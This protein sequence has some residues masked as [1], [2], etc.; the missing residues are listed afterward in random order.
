MKKADYPLTV[1]IVMLC[2]LLTTPVFSYNLLH[3]DTPS[4]QEYAASQFIYTRP[5]VRIGYVIPSDRSPQ[6]LGPETLQRVIR[7]AQVWYQEQMAL[8]GFA[9]K[10]FEF[11]KG[12]A[13]NPAVNIIHVDKTAAY[14]R[15]DPWTRTIA[16]ARAAG[17]NVATE[18]QVWLLVPEIHVQNPDGTV[19]DSFAFGSGGLSGRDAGIA[20]IGSDALAVLGMNGFNNDSNINGKI[21]PGLGP[22]PAN[23]PVH[24]GSTVSKVTSLNMGAILH[25]LGH[26]F[27]LPHDDRIDLYAF[28]HLMSSAYRSARSAFYPDLYPNEATLLSWGAALRLDVSHYFN[29]SLE[30]NEGPLVIGKIRSTSP[31]NGKLVFEY[32]ANDPDGLSCMFIYNNFFRKGEKELKGTTDKGILEIYDYTPGVETTFEMWVY[33]DEGNLTVE[34][35]TFTPT[36]NENRAPY[37]SFLWTPFRPTLENGNRVEFYANLSSD[38]DHNNSSLLFQWDFDSD[39]IF[40]TELSED[41]SHNHQFTN[42]GPH[43]IRLKVLDP[44]GAFSISPPLPIYIRETVPVELASFEVSVM[45]SVV[46]L[47]WTTASESKNYGFAVQ[48]ARKAAEPEWMTLDIVRGNGT[49]NKT[50]QYSYTDENPGS[51]TF[52]YRL[53]QMDTDGAFTLTGIREVEVQGL[54]AFNLMQ[55]HPNP[56]NSATMIRFRIDREQDVKFALI[57]L[58]GQIVRSRELGRLEAGTHSIQL[59]ADDLPSGVYFYQIQGSRHSAVKK[60]TI[61]R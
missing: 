32:Y 22:Y 3:D 58:Q 47:D 1:Y 24:W 19:D 27:G 49:T 7:Q 38:P 26:A 11:E 37:P 52:L 53:K 12:S 5:I 57:N 42:A 50:H 17:F 31:I 56:F 39:L 28:G 61:L 14:L 21:I 18:R 25:V 8:Y 60:L 23:F 6:T 48:R 9:S 35:I 4:F 55:N 30:D 54:S 10:T 41:D 46:R 34:D 51:G 33:D 36:N 40:D 44:A 43:L 45:N 16:A 15:Q 29:L 2:I 13:L 20:M 59:A